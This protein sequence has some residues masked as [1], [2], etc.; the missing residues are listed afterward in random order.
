M[1]HL[2]QEDP[3]KAAS[4]SRLTSQF[5]LLRQLRRETEALGRKAAQL[6]GT[7]DNLQAKLEAQ[8]EELSSRVRAAQSESMQVPNHPVSSPFG[9]PIAPLSWGSGTVRGDLSA[10]APPSLSPCR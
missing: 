6:Q 3:R 9:V 10:C 7:N 1:Q 4:S 5:L 2:L 8:R